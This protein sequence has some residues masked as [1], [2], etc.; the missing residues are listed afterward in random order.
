MRS[1]RLKATLILPRRNLR[2]NNEC[3]P[4]NFYKFSSGAPGSIRFRAKLGFASRL[5]RD[6]T[7]I[8]DTRFAKPD[9]FTFV[10]YHRPPFLNPVPAPA[11]S[12]VLLP[13]EAGP[14]VSAARLVA[15]FQID[16]GDRCPD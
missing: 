2:N 14:M 4:R 5:A 15:V 1:R 7:P 8:S 3:A 13:L 11:L 16:A 9:E 10:P 6:S 12:A